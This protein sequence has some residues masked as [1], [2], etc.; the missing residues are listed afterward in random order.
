MALWRESHKVSVSYLSSKA[1]RVTSR[2]PLSDTA[3][4][5]MA[6]WRE[7]QKVSVSYLSSHRW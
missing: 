7:S 4:V 3:L 1:C 2:C 6:L 5:N